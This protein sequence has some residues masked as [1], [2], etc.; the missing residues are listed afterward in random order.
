MER[1]T[2]AVDQN[3][4]ENLGQRT[5][6]NQARD[7]LVLVQLVA[8]HI[9]REPVEEVQT[10]RTDDASDESPPNVGTLEERVLIYRRLPRLT[11]TLTRVPR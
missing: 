11:S 6:R 2:A 4:V 9:R 10:E 3:G 5:H 1:R 8:A 7:R